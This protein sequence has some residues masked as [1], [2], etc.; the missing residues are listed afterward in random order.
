MD[1]S[2]NLASPDEPE[3]LKVKQRESR[4]FNPIRDLPDLEMRSCGRLAIFLLKFR[5]LGFL[6]S[7]SAADG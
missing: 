2:A 5:H 3:G 1:L 4:S 6:V 7:N